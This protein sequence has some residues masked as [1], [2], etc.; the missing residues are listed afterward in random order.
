MEK[1][2][3]RGPHACRAKSFE[4]NGPIRDAWEVAASAG[5]ASATAENSP[6]FTHRQW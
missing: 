1:K 5:E 3:H 6:L 4:V 2:S